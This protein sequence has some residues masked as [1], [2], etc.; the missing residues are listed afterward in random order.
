MTLKLGIMKK[1]ELAAWFGVTE[2]S[3]ENARKKYLQKLEPFAKFIEIRGGV[4]IEEIYI[5]TFVKNLD[6]DV[7][8][9]LQEVQRAED[10]I[11]SVSGISEIL[12]AKE[13]FNDITFETMRGR[14]TRAGVKAFGVTKEEDSRGIYGSRKYIWAIKLYDMPNHYRYMTRE[15][16]LRFDEIVTDFYSTSAERVKKLPYQKKLLEQMQP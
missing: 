15:E 5:S 12:C 10:N 4:M 16:E 9:Y 13:E 8:L 7:N 3:F 6:N 1:K 2:K 11:T 14:M